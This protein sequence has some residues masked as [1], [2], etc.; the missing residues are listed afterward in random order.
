MGS[1]HRLCKDPAPVDRTHPKK[2]PVAPATGDKRPA[3]DQGVR[4]G[5]PHLSSAPDC[6]GLPAVCCPPAAADSRSRRV[7]Q[8]E[9]RLVV[10]GLHNGDRVEADALVGAVQS[11]VAHAEPGHGRDAQAGQVV[12]D[13]GQPRDLRSRG[14]ASLR[15]RRSNASRNGEPTTETPPLAATGSAGSGPRSA[16]WSPSFGTSPRSRRFRP[17]ATGG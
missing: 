13:V 14:Q 16:Q 5:P 15:R 1:N 2:V 12:T 3:A 10:C 7:Q 17:P 11:L 4:P 9:Q 6:G 8:G